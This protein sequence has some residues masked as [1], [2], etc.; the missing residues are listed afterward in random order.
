MG[1]KTD[2]SFALTLNVSSPEIITALEFWDDEG[3]PRCSSVTAKNRW[4][5]DIMVI[6]ANSYN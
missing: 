2:R 5:W 6:P 1:I 3:T 4:R